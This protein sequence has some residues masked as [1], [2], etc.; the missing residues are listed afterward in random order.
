M[1]KEVILLFM[2]LLSPLRAFGA[3]TIAGDQG[4]SRSPGVSGATSSVVAV[5]GIIVVVFLIY[6]FVFKKKK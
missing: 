5:I 2:L 4:V 6:W 3:F 1:K